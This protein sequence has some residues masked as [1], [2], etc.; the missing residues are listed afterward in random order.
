VGTPPLTPKDT[1]GLI[2][3]N[4]HATKLCSKTALFR[5]EP[6]LAAFPFPSPAPFLLQRLPFSSDYHSP[7]PTNLQRLPFSSD[8][9]SPAPAILAPTILQRL[10]F[11]SA[12]HF[13]A[14]TMRNVGAGEA[15][16]LENLLKFLPSRQCFLTGYGFG[17]VWTRRD[18]AGLQWW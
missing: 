6:E 15:K 13:P 9:H 7:A 4:L 14:P 3:Q 18:R 12:Y 1:P 2:R 10:P 8:Y 11:S 5:Q 17:P 16:G